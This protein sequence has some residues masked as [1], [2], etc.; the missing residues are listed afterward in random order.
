MFPQTSPRS[1][2]TYFTS[3][4]TPSPEQNAQPRLF[5][6]DPFRARFGADHRLPR[7]LREE[8]RGMEWSLFAATYAPMPELR[9]SRL[10][11]AR[12]R[13]GEYRFTAELTR[14]S[15]TAQPHAETRE[16]TAAGPV[17]ACTHLLADAG[18]HVEILSFHQS[19]LYEATVTFLHVGH[20]THHRRRA[21]AMGFGASPEASAA[22]ALSSGAQLIYG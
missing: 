22:A 3:T 20:Q 2:V 13:G 9:I 6:E 16:I 5:A 15:K 7:G 19:E 17:S 1:T 4:S 21:W 14:T 11:S 18:R 10:E 12:M 8:A